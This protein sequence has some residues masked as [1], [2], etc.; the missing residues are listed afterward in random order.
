M[1][2]YGHDHGKKSAGQSQMKCGLGVHPASLSA[3]RRPR[4][5]WNCPVSADLWAG[6]QAKKNP[7][8]GGVFSYSNASDRS[9]QLALAS[10]REQ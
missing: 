3:V 1:Y 9:V 5:C 7:A 2:D 4:Q 8:F 10:A 6:C